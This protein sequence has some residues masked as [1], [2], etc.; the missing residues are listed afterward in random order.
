M[1]DP[2]S[3]IVVSCDPETTV[4]VVENPHWM[5][6]AAVELRISGWTRVG[7]MIA[8]ARLSPKGAT[9]LGEWLV[10]WAKE[11]KEDPA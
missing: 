11:H 4:T 2:K 5:N 7:P 8:D 6:P 1:S 9:R 10:A 3:I